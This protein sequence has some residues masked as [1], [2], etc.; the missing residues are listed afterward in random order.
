MKSTMTSTIFFALLMSI[1]TGSL[2]QLNSGQ[3]N[4]GFKEYIIGK[5]KSD[6]KFKGCGHSIEGRKDFET[7]L[8]PNQTTTIADVSAQITN[9]VFK[10]GKLFYLEIDLKSNESNMAAINAALT[11]KFGNP[12]PE[13]STDPS[14]LRR[15]TADDNQINSESYSDGISAIMFFNRD[16]MKEFVDAQKQ[17]REAAQAKK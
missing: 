10:D 6:F 8:P 5:S 14:S 15:W 2:A 16:L 12:L 17:A 11:E 4:F 9:V 3:G 13:R 7:C 1:S